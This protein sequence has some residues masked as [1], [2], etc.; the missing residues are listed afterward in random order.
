MKL[1]TWLKATGIKYQNQFGM[2]RGSKGLIPFIKLNGHVVEDSQKCIEYL[3][4]IYQIDMNAHLTDEQRALSRLIIK[5][6]DDSLKW[7]MAMFRFVLYENKMDAD[8]LPLLAYWNFGYR[9]DKAAKFAGY[10]M[11]RDELFLNGKKDL[12]ALNVLVGEN[13]YFFSND[14]PSEADFAV[15]GLVAELLWTDTG[16]INKYL[17]GNFLKKEF[18]KN[19]VIWQI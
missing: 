1:E 3:T 11:T 2:T 19:N 6:C 18:L 17:R 4:E 14:K 16:V 7:T 8:A 5:L 9:I 10:G 12:D 15:F 13:K